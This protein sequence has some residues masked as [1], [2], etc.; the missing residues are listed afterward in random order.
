[1]LDDGTAPSERDA[2]AAKTIAL[3]YASG[4]SRID[5]DGD[6]RIDAAGAAVMDAFW[7]RAARAVLDPVLGSLT[8]RLAELNPVDDYANSQGSSYDNGWYGYV[9]KDLRTALGQPV[10]SPFHER[11]CGGG[12]LAACSAS[13]WAAIDAAADELEAQQGPDPFSWRADA[14]PER[15]SFEPGLIPLTM[16]WTNRPT[17]QQVI[18]FSGHRPR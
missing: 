14:T 2:A 12:S 4:S 7:P 8:E 15:I 13:L 16:R 6:G 5:A 17:F 18:T 11:Y 9:D 10:R 3:W 1:V